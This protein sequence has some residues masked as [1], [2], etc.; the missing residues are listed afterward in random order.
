MSE[1]NVTRKRKKKL[2]IGRNTPKG[3]PLIFLRRETGISALNKA[4]ALLWFCGPVNGRVRIGD[5]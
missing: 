5:L 3:H 1:K 4:L 2:F